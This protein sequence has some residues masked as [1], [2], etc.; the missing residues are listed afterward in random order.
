MH[1]V[2]SDPRWQ[3][4]CGLDMPLLCLTIILPAILGPLSVLLVLHVRLL[5]ALLRLL[6]P[7]RL[8]ACWP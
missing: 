2:T 3:G 6:A 5:L 1:A 7:W 8:C 4:C